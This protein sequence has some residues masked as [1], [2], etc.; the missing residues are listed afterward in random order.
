MKCLMSR[1]N[2]VAT[3][4]MV[5]MRKII[6]FLLHLLLEFTFSELMLKFN[7]TMLVLENVLHKVKKKSRDFTTKIPGT[8]VTN[9]VVF[10]FTNCYLEECFKM[11]P[12]T[13]KLRFYYLRGR[14]ERTNLV[15]T[16][17]LA[18]IH[19]HIISAWIRVHGIGACKILTQAAGKITAFI[20]LY[21]YNDFI[22]SQSLCII[23][24]FLCPHILLQFNW[25]TTRLE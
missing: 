20:A 7:F 13:G 10:K 22:F 14:S 8:P 5:Y 9:I 17:L 24:R 16:L 3:G 23:Y 6:W 19:V 12:V 18:R 11:F 2:Y 15:F 21:V 4:C 25:T 1:K